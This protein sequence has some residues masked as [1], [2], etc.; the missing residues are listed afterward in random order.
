[1]LKALVILVAIVIAVVNVS[2]QGS[3]THRRVVRKIG[4][5]RVGPSTTYLK[6]GLSTEEVVR[7]LG[8]PSAIFQREKGSD[9]LTYVF[10]RSE[11]RVLVAEFVKGALVSSRTETR[12]NID[13]AGR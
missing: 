11:G 4:V 13:A 5:V 7:L 8:E 9:A 3:A 6:Q 1:M 2:A 10:E 12:Q